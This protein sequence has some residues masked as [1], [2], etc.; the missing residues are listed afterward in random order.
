MRDP[1][2]DH[3]HNKDRPRAF[4]GLDLKRSWGEPGD[5]DFSLEELELFADNAAY[6]AGLLPIPVPSLATPLFER[7]AKGSARIFFRELG[8]TGL[9]AFIVGLVFHAPLIWAFAGEEIASLA[10]TLV[11]EFPE[12]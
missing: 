3:F 2:L 8:K 1:D 4:C 11:G 10:I 5:D 6:V 7:I 9:Y 12:F